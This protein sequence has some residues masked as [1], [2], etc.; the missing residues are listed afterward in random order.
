MAAEAAPST[1]F[2]THMLHFLGLG[3][4]ERRGLAPKLSPECKLFWAPYLL[5]EENDSFQGPCHPSLWREA[6]CLQKQ[7]LG[8]AEGLGSGAGPG[9]HPHWGPSLK[10]C[11]CQGNTLS[12]CCPLSQGSRATFTKVLSE[13][14]SRKAD[15]RFL[16]STAPGKHNPKLRLEAFVSLVHT[17]L[18][19]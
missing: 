11:D 9:A 5:Q 4:R 18:S 7:T 13:P 14:C 17:S 3:P 8:E 6:Q 1:E 2:T 16:A 19:L 15:R 10:G 12:P